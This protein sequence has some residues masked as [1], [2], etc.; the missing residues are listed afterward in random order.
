[1]MIMKKNGM[2]R[3]A[4]FI[5]GLRQGLARSI[6][7]GRILFI[8]ECFNELTYHGMRELLDGDQYDGYFNKDG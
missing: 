4:W 6:C 3:E 7:D 2:L 5:D 1:M 8:G